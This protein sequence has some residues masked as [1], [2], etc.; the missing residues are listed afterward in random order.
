MTAHADAAP[1]GAADIAGRQ[2]NVHEGA[3]G[4]VIVVAP[5]Q[6]LLI[7]EHRPPASAAL[8]G[9]GDPARSL[10]DVVRLET[11][12]PGGFIDADLVRGEHFVKAGRRFADEITIE[13]SLRRDLGHQRVEEDQIGARFER[14]MKD[15]RLSGRIFA[16]IDRDRAPRVDDDDPDRFMLLVRELLALFIGRGPSHV[17]QPVIEEV[18]RLRLERVGS[19]G[20]DRVGEF[21]VLV[22][23]VELAHAHVAGGMDLG[24]VGGAIV[25][26]DV[27]DLH[28]VEIELAGG[29]GVFVTAAGAAMVK[30]GDDQ[31]VLALLLDDAAG[32]LGGEPQRVV[33]GCR[34]HAAVAIDERFREPLA[35]R[36]GDRRERQFALARAADRAK[37]GIYLAI[38]V[39]LDDELHVAAVL[40][41][42]VVHRRREPIRGLCFLLPREI[43]AEEVV[44]CLGP[45]LLVDIPA[46]RLVT[47][48]DDAERAGDVVDFC[49][50]GRDRQAV[51][52][53][54]VGHRSSPLTLSGHC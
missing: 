17:R 20:N 44:G 12:D 51:D 30:G 4:P 29:P 42:D 27:L 35:L 25:D 53:A 37:A 15:V 28:A 10:A 19:D 8:L 31:A 38:L 13:P 54:L 11:R 52:V 1:A 23:I 41:D 36:A 18:I 46:D 5:D 3:V 21:G 45:A 24:I 2:R 48:A 9:F 43:D 22:A 6:A 50:L 26:A 47:A 39:R 33:P 7:G 34:D 49:V 32:H 14:Q 16:G 40:L